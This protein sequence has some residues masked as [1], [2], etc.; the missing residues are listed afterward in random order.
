VARRAGQVD[1]ERMNETARAL[2]VPVD[3]AEL[4]RLLDVTNMA[5]PRLPTMARTGHDG[6]VPAALVTAIRPAWAAFG[7]LLACLAVGALTDPAVLTGALV[8]L[9]AVL[10][11]T[12]TTLVGILAAVTPSPPAPGRSAQQRADRDGRP[13]QVHPDAPGHRRPRA[14]GRRAPARA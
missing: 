2:D 5:D 1:D 6:E 13:R 9:A 4:D 11:V 3:D 14:P 8:T 12:A 7:M 10:A